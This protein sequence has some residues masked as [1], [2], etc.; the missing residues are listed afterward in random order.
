MSEQNMFIVAFVFKG[1]TLNK[2]RR[3]DHDSLSHPE[4]RILMSL[5]YNNAILFIPL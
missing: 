3:L 1:A 5:G 4:T 2:K